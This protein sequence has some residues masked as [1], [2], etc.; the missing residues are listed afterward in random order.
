MHRET[1]APTHKHTPQTHTHTCFWDQFQSSSKGTNQQHPFISWASTLPLHCP[2]LSIDL[3]HS[4]FLGFHPSSTLTFYPSN[5]ALFPHFPFTFPSPRPPFPPTHPQAR[6]AQISL[7]K[8]NFQSII[9]CWPSGEAAHH[10]WRGRA[11]SEH[12]LDHL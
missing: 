3:C 5:P 1:E 6:R 8:V 12:F 9:S 10:L 4:G 2:L 7:N 11:L